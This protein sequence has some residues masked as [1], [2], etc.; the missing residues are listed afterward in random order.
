LV[1]YKGV[2][3]LVRA[4]ER[5]ADRPIA[6]SIHGDFR[7]EEDAHHAELERLAGDN[8]RFHGRF[9]NSRLSEVY[10]EIDVL[11]VP[12]VW[13]ENSPITIHEAFLTRTPV[14]ASDIGGMAE[15]VRDGVD[16]LT[17][18]VG[19]DAALAACLARFA[20]EPELLGRLSRD[21]PPVKTIEQDAAL[22]EA[23]Y[24]SLCTRVRRRGEAGMAVLATETAARRGEV[25]PQG[26]HLLL[27][28]PDR[29]AV[30]YDLAGTGSGERVVSVD[31]VA[32]AGE[33][34]VELAGRVSIDGRIVG[35]LPRFRGG[36]REIVK[37]ICLDVRLP[38]EG[39]RTLTLENL[40]EAGAP[41]YL[42][43]ARVAVEPAPHAMD[44]SE[45]AP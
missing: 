21:F 10:A 19:D 22:T 17:F 16:G 4:M 28:R 13:F 43:V 37:R 2:D 40:D 18:A 8:V 35:H 20:D 12:S 9:D 42:R 41:C 11:A 26:G 31:V 32:L 33:P 5:L 29:A 6:L 38:E 7:P 34:E 1:W 23:R 24:R 45:T 44:Q 39:A 27:L 25:E 15:Y 14:V 3:V 30:D 36:K